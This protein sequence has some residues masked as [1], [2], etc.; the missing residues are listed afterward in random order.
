[1]LDEIVKRLVETLHPLEIYLFGSHARGTPDR[2][3]RL[4]LSGGRA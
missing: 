1:M 2:D 3:K 4:G